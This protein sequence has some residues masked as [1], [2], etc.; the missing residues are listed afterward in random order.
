MSFQDKDGTSLVSLQLTESPTIWL[1]D[2][3][4][5]SVEKESQIG[6]EVMS[7]NE[8]YKNILANRKIHIDNFTD[9]GIQTFAWASKTKDVQT[10]YHKSKD[11]S[12]MAT[13]WDIFDSFTKEEEQEK[14]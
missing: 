12:I 4:G 5:S 13:E 14:R 10:E 3:P 7:R 11:L 9:K 6:Q 1:I 2:V 8:V